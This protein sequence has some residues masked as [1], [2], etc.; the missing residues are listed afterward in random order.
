MLTEI[1]SF[2]DSM[3]KPQRMLLD[4]LSKH[5][6]MEYD[7]SPIWSLYVTIPNIRR[8]IESSVFDMVLENRIEY[9]TKRQSVT[10]YVVTLICLLICITAV[11]F[12]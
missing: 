10:G 8:S 11:V 1:E 2:S 6:I 4:N 9:Q 3:Y 5:T 7:G 12:F